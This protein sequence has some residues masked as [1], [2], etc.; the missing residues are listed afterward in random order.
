M[1]SLT[2]ESAPDD[3]LPDV[4]PRKQG[5]RERGASAVIF[6]LLL[7]VVFGAVAL[8]V[9][10]GRLAY[11]RQH[12]SNAL[13][14]AALAGA[15]SLPTDPAGAKTSA[16]AF[17]KANDPQ[18]DPAVS[19][20]CVVG[21]TGA[22]KTVVSGQVPSVCDPGTVAGAKC[23]EV[24]CAIPC[25][26]GSGHTCNT[27][28]VT[29]DK[30]VPFVFAPVIGINTGNTGSLAADACRGSCGAQ[31]PNP[32]NVAILADRTS[33][34]SDT[35]LSSLQSGIQ[36]T[37][38]T[39]TKDQQY[40]AL[41]T[42]G[43][44]SSTSG[45]ITNPSGSK[46]SG[47]WLPVPF[48]NDYNTAASPPALNTG[49]DLVKG[50][51]CLA[52][53]ST[54]TSLAS[55]TK[56]AARYL[57]GLD[58]N[59]LGSLPARSGTP[60][61]AIILETDGQPNEPDVSGSTSVGTAGDIGSSN[62]VTACNNLKAVAA[63]AKS[64]GVLIVTVGYNLSTERCGGSGEYVRDVLAAAASPDS[65]GNPSTANG[66]STAAEIT[67]EN[68]D[69]DYFFCAGSGTALGPI[70]VSAINAISGNSRLIRIPS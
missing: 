47:S 54:G 51:Q 61:N 20:W 59:N 13:D 26:P 69:G 40:V 11:E 44:S 34:M 48:S 36:S 22:A 65:N 30:D 29:D 45:C 60:R 42:I 6:A 12:L 57:L 68:S 66:C 33:S 3:R 27:I 31:S 70:F 1:H 7:P 14:A 15:S 16:L 10:F 50:L 35:D 24:I 4:G 53:S 62:G 64:R 32:M 56:A 41:G 39:M 2:S 17:A 38:Q 5:S 49:S 8:A 28:T 23:N 37:L 9:D 58:P 18:A 55:P 21:S 63:D 46:T 67:A 25:I 43:R 52:H 19:F